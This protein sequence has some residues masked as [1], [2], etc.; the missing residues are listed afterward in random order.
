MR[1]LGML[2]GSFALVLGLTVLHHHLALADGRVQGGTIGTSSEPIKTCFVN[3][4]TA[5]VRTDTSLGTTNDTDR[6]DSFNSVCDFGARSRIL[7][8][9]FIAKAANAAM[10]LYDAA[11]VPTGTSVAG[12]FEEDD[13][14]TAQ[15]A[16]SVQMWPHP[17]MLTTDLSVV[18]R[19]G[20]VIVYYL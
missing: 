10:G 15:E 4:T 5:G 17:Y 12:L 7:G 1:R 20:V 19:D 3:G 8:Y 2:L 11:T 6:D 18:V 14:D 16:G 9:K 13:E